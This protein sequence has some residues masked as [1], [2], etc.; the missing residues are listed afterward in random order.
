M[1]RRLL[2][3]TIMGEIING[4]EFI[5]MGLSVK[6]ATCNIGA[7]KLTDYGWYFMWGDTKAYNSDRIPVLGGGMQLAL[8]GRTISGVMER[9]IL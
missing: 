9:C 2:N 6:W 1:R 4:Y 7:K 8:T 3:Q 5:D